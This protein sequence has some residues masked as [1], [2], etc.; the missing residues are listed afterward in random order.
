MA[1]KVC[2]VFI[3]HIHEDDDRLAPLKELL[4]RNDCQARDSSVN[5]TNPNRAKDPD[6]IMRKILQPRID[7]AG[8]MV[9]L[10]TPDTKDSDWVNRE[11]EYAHRQ[12]KRIVGIWDLGHKECEVPKMLGEYA[13]AMVAWRADQIIRA[14]FK[15]INDWRDPEGNPRADREIPRHNC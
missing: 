2:N 15:D 13:D 4:D 7:W 14:I 1:K 6:Y 8:T 5:S 3:S 11:I 9:V 12:D 10:V